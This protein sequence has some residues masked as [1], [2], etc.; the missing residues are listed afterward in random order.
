MAITLYAQGISDGLFNPYICIRYVQIYQMPPLYFMIFLSA[1]LISRP[2]QKSFPHYQST[3][4]SF[5]TISP[6]KAYSFPPPI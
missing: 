1:A 5:P 6:L 4:N 2:S 3:P